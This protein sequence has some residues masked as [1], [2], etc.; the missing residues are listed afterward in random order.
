M[1]KHPHCPLARN[2][3]KIAILHYSSWPVIG[4][5]ESVVRQHAELMVKHGHEVMIICG[6]GSGF[7][8]QVPTQ[9][10]REL[11][12]HEAK[13]QA[14]QDEIY[15]GHPGSA[16]FRLVEGLRSKLEHNI[17]TMPFDLAAT[18]VLANIAAGGIKMIAWTHDLAARNPHYKIP[19]SR[20]FNLIRERL[21]NVKYVTISDSR[22]TEFRELTGT[23]PDRV[24]QNGLGFREICAVTPEVAELVE[25]DLANSMILLFPTRI[26][27]RKNILFALQ[28][29]AAIRDSG[30]RVRLLVTGAPDPHNL[31]SVGYFAALKRQAADLKIDRLVTWV[32]ELFFV[33][34]R[35][36]RS[37]Y[38]VSDGVLFPSRQEGFGL[39][40]LEGAAYRIPVFCSDIEPLKSIAP[41]GTLLFNIRDAPRTVAARI[42]A[43]LEGSDLFKGRKHVLTNYSAEQIFIEKIE[44]LLL[45]K[46]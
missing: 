30:A 14:A 43:N 2:S 29:V 9:T 45:E 11:N 38:G 40:L 36:M 31:A 27:E 20:T 17:F 12:S 39:P 18:E 23:D 44:P 15:K 37:L 5:V 24:I 42:R 34:E 16:Y 32:N 33:D 19:A 6:E 4:G 7:S 13:V 41:P 26:L 21:P 8:K 46:I 25:N 3:M 28:I 10:I 1:Q 35:Q 22:G